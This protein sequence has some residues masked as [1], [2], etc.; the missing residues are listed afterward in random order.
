M[1]IFVA[2]RDFL[3]EKIPDRPL[4]YLIFLPVL[5]TA[6]IPF[7]LR[8]HRADSLILGGMSLFILGAFWFI[9]LQTVY[10]A[11]Q[12]S[13]RDWHDSVP[14]ELPGTANRE[15]IIRAKF[16]AVV[17]HRWRWHL[18]AT[19]IIG[20]LALATSGFLSRIPMIEEIITL[21]EGG[22][23]IGWRPMEGSLNRGILRDYVTFT[24]HFPEHLLTVLPH[25]KAFAF[26]G[27]FLL[28]SNIASMSLSIATG[29]AM[30]R[31]NNVSRPLVGR[32]S[33]AIIGLVIFGAMFFLRGT[34]LGNVFRVPFS[35]Q[36]RQMQVNPYNCARI[37]RETFMLR[38][39][40]STEQV[41]MAL[42]DGGTH[43]TAVLL[44]TSWDPNGYLADSWIVENFFRYGNMG[45]I[46][47]MFRHI[48]ILLT[49][50]A[51]Q[52]LLSIGLLTMASRSIGGK[53]KT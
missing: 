36:C 28:I 5:L 49:A 39:V 4:Y 6:C 13:R 14:H 1:S 35:D 24:I 43:S 50:S 48:L 7:F 11:L 15:Q 8:I 45:S 21:P 18:L 26:G 32:A 19:I 33:I 37:E 17:A 34:V 3:R 2:E 38:M 52:I 16:M 20:G 27:F 9:Q 44:F 25:P 42:V 31:Y 40:E 22:T 51:I 47:F 41:G 46:K 30:G 10:T 53:K 23:T 29:L 12:S